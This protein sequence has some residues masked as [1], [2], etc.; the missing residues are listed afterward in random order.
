MIAE[1]LSTGDEIR[2]G[3]IMDSNAAYISQKLEEAGLP[4]I[5]HNC[6]GDDIDILVSVLEEIGSR[7]DIAVVTG[8]LGPTMD[9]LTAEAA[10]KAA[11]VELVLNDNALSSI[12]SFYS[13]RNRRMPVLSEKMALLPK[14]AECLKNR[15]GSAPGFLLVIGRCRF[16]F[17]PGVPFE[18]RSMLSNQVLPQLEKL[19]G[20]N[21]KFFAV[22]TLSTFGLTESQTE[23]RLAG[24]SA[25][26]SEIKLGL[27][28]DFPEIQIKLY[29]NGRNRKRLE[30]IITAA[31][32]WIWP[33]IGRNLFSIDGGSMEG[34]VGKLLSEQQ[35]TLAVAE[36]CTG[37]LISHLLTNVAGSSDYF[38]FSGVTYSNESKIRVLGVSAAT[39]Q[40]YGAVHTEVVKEMAEGVRRLTGA[41][42]GLSTSGIAGPGG[43]TDDKP[44]GTLCI[45]L[46]TA[47]SSRGCQ[48]NFSFAQ[49]SMNKKIFA[50]KALDLLRRELLDAIGSEEVQSSTL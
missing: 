11:K 41:T 20:P 33:K 44:V 19:Q 9:D 32:K 47:K 17:L 13:S 27:R 3:A 23:E 46:S 42:Y 38:L 12:K 40:Q 14:G 37:G 18:M 25:K 5:R 22:K 36:S 43:G 26:F 8:G 35:A 15:V 24:F 28:V 7:T 10:A 16:F 6:V 2:S 21:R 45:G 49:R 4:V 29:C 34:V 48:Y 39:L 30:E 50:V 1:I 31:C